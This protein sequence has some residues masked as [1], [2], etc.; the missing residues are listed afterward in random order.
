MQA[1]LGSGCVMVIGKAT[2]DADYKLVGAKNSALCKFGLVV[3]RNTDDSPRY[4]NVD[5]WW[6]IADYCKIIKKGDVVQAFGTIEEREYKGKIYKTLRAE[7]VNVMK[8]IT[9]AP[10][11]NENAD[12]GF[13]EVTDDD[14]PF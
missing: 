9:M 11:Q 5:A 1:S 4:A 3:G 12:D 10:S 6:D 7:Y 13:V 14:L 2:N 8:K